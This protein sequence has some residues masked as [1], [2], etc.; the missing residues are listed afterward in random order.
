MEWQIIPWQRWWHAP[1]VCLCF[2]EWLRDR[3]HGPNREVVPQS[4]GFGRFRCL[5]DV[6]GSASPRTHLVGS[7]LSRSP[8]RTRSSSSLYFFLFKVFKVLKTLLTIILCTSGLYEHFYNNVQ[9]MRTLF[10][11]S[12]TLFL[13]FSRTKLA[14]TVSWD[15]FYLCRLDISARKKLF[16]QNISET[17][18]KIGFWLI[19]M[20]GTHILK[21]QR[22]GT[23]NTL[24]MFIRN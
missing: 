10:L 8:L 2:G 21:V 22:L 13:S 1:Q 23:H 5:E 24:I 11:V 4:S 15:H 20:T 18:L 6:A 3:D 16:H 7:L 19:S 17:N 14:T 12:G 9:Q